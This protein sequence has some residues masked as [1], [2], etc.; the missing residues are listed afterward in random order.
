MSTKISSEALLNRFEQL[1][2][3]VMRRDCSDNQALQQTSWALSKLASERPFA[4]YSVRGRIQ[5]LNKSL[6][7][8]LK[9]TV[10][11]SIASCI[12]G[13]VTLPFRIVSVAL[14]TLLVFMII[15]TKSVCSKS[16]GLNPKTITNPK[17]PIILIHG[18]NGSERQWDM[19]RCFLKGKNTGHIFGL[20]LSESAFKNDEKS[21]HQF[22]EQK[23]VTEISNMK[24]HYKDAGYNLDKVILVGYSMGGLVAGDYATTCINETGVGVEA[25]VTVSTPWH[26]S[27]MAHHIYTSD[28]KPEGAFITGCESTTTLRNNVVEKSK[29]GMP[30]YT[31]NASLDYL[32]PMWSSSLPIDPAHQ[33]YRSTHSHH[34][35]LMDPA[36]AW[37]V[38]DRFLA[39]NTHDLTKVSGGF[40]H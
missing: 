5:E 15:K 16:S 39:P 12:V 25:L 31:F 35:F 8:K 32:V 7:D 18:S 23:L 29:N 37:E 10:P 30:L 2:R 11:Q 4:L 1:E 20:S 13:K 27:P 24:E 14:R 38:R 19:F 17:T 3:A 22:A 33:I 36:V 9:I 21:I 40:S 34:S 28:H 26:G 6:G